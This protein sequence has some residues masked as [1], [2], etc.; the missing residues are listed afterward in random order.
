MPPPPTHWPCRVSSPSCWP[1]PRQSRAAWAWLRTRAE[2]DVYPAAVGLGVVV[3][4]LALSATGGA[5]NRSIVLAAPSV[6]CLRKVPLPLLALL[7]GAT[8]VTSAFVSRAFFAGTL[9]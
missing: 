7:A 5:W 8:A 1:R 4:I 2:G 9:V 3:G 6:I